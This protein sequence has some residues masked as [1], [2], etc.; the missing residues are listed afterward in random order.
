MLLDLTVGGSNVVV[1]GGQSL[2]ELRVRSLVAQG[3]RVHVVA[4]R[5]APELRSFDP[6]LVRLVRAGPSDYLRAI[7]RLRPLIV[8]STLRSHRV[9]LRIV[10]LAHSIG[11]LVNVV[12]TPAL[13][14][15]TMPAV[16]NVGAIRVAVATGGLSPAMARL[17][18]DRILR[19]VR[20]E[21]ALQVE[22]QGRVR[23]AMLERVPSAAERRELVYR[24]VSDKGISRLLRGDKLDLALARALRLVEAAAATERPGGSG[25]P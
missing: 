24:I 9:N 10:R 6:L 16:G 15:F 23:K 7:R 22:L 21:D 25:G 14:D 5:F 20:P 19:A 18:R 11:S 13:C 17:V 4:P 2:S 8:M 3:I 1:V 12:D